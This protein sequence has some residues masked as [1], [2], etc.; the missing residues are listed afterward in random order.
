MDPRTAEI[1]KNLND[2]TS[3]EQYVIDACS[4]YLAYMFSQ[5]QP[6]PLAWS[7]EAYSSQSRYT[8]L[9]KA[10]ILMRWVQLAGESRLAPVMDPAYGLRVVEQ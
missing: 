7:E 9:G 3:N 8:G 10:Q 4:T 2:A 5:V 6:V 1:L